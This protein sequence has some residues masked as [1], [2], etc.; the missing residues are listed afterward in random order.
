MQVN[1]IIGW[2]IGFFL[3]F[4]FIC[5]IL[6]LIECSNPKLLPFLDSQITAQDFYSSYTARYARR[7]K[8]GWV[9]TSSSCWLMIDFLQRTTMTTIT[10]RGS[11]AMGVYSTSFTIDYSNNGNTFETFKEGGSTKVSM[12]LFNFS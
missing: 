5:I 1:A 3:T 9:S 11:T 7:D 8:S 12:R 4:S 6:Y 2:L 10:V